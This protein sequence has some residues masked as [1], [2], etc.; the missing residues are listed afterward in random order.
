MD[1]R[2]TS[3]IKKQLQNQKKNWRKDQPNEIWEKRGKKAESKQIE[4][5]GVVNSA[6][7][8]YQRQN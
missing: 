7:K 5:V 2:N 4:K 3:Q 1:F 8:E 6:D